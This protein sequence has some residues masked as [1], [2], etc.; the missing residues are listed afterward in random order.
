MVF[1]LNAF[2]SLLE[3]FL[4]NL[5]IFWLLVKNTWWIFLPLVLF[6]ILKRTYLTY[7][8]VRYFRNLKW[9]LLEV[10]IPR[11]VAKPPLAMEQIFAGLHSAY[12]AFDFYEK[13]V[14]GIQQD[15]FSVEVAGIGGEIHFYFYVPSYYRNLIEALVYSQYPESEI[16]EVEDYF[17]SLPD[18]LPNNEFEIFGSEF[19]LAKED[20]YPIRTYKEFSIEDISSKEEMRKVDPF[21]ALAEVLGKLRPGEYVGIQLLIKPTGDKWK[22]EGEALVN[23]LIGKK[24][25]TKKPF[26]SKIVAELHGA[27]NNVVGVESKP[28]KP[29]VDEKGTMMQHLSPGEKEVVVAIERNI[30]KIGFET[31]LR[32]IYVA[33]RD[34]FDMAS[35][36]SINAVLRQY[37]T[38][39]LNGFKINGASLTG[40]R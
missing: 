24:T 38:Q 32:F 5:Y 15:Y 26:V 7:L 2:F 28:S 12:R 1:A 10:R 21:S 40:P 13:Y 35:F 36:S 6:F 27:Y 17:S 37:N 9:V 22:K 39:N 4:N 18:D 29:A 33:R 31:V 11:E 14:N 25:A 23:K 16:R 30:A 8:I 34:V 19:V 3:D 20:G